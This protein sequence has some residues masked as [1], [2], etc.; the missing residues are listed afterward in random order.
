MIRHG[1][2]HVSRPIITIMLK[3]P[4]PNNDAAI[5]SRMIVGKLI[6]TSTPRMTAKSAL[7]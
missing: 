5:N 7:R 3:M 6:T 1:I 2:V 4:G